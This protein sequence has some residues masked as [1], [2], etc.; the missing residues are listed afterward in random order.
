MLKLRLPGFT[1]E[2]SLYGANEGYQV[3]GDA[4]RVGDI[5]I[6]SVAPM[7]GVTT[8]DCLARGLCA[9][10]DTRGHVTCGKCPGQARALGFAA[11]P[12]SDSFAGGPLF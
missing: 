11:D 3:A 6:N 7:L 2:Y 10:V 1:A 4:A 5:F 8:D 12:A 9:Y